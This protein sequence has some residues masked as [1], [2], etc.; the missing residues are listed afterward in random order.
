MNII[1]DMHPAYLFC[2]PETQAFPAK[3]SIV[4]RLEIICEV[5]GNPKVHSE[6]RHRHS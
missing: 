1:K 2:L 6:N 4:I 5:N 3:G